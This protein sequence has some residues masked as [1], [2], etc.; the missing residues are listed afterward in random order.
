MLEHLGRAGML[1]ISPCG[2]YTGVRDEADLVEGRT[3]RGART[4]YP[5][6]HLSNDLF[7]APEG[8]HPL[9]GH[10]TDHFGSGAAK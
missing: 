7:R 5:E 1:T 2:S 9:T 3:D 4:P 10:V 6:A 8:Q